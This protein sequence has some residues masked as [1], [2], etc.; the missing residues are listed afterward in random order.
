MNGSNFNIIINLNCL[1]PPIIGRVEVG[2]LWV[3]LSLHMLP[4]SPEAGL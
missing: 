4:H 1:A 3:I 2:G